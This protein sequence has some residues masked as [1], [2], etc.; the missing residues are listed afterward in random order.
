M[1]GSRHEVGLSLLGV[2]KET[3]EDGIGGSIETMRRC[4]CRQEKSS[5]E[6]LRWK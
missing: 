4:R 3:R 6:H 2:M 1:K 5:W